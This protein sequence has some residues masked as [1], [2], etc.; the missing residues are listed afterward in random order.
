MAGV[1]WRRHAPWIALP[2]GALQSLA[3]AP[4]GLWPLG[5][6]ALVVLW[7]L[8]DGARAREA[9][10]TGFAFGAGL[11]LAGTYWLYTSIHTF[12]EAPIALALVLMLGL[13]AIMGSYTALL[14]ALVARLAPA[15]GAWRSLAALPAGWILM[16]WVRGWFLS[17]FPWLAVGYSQIDAPLVGYAP[18]LG[19]YGTG[20]ATAFTAGAVLLAASLPSRHRVLLLAAVA[21]LWTGGAVLARVEWT[22][23]S[24]PP[25]TVALVQPSISQDLKWQVSN[26]DHTLELYRQMTESALGARLVVWPES[27][28]PEAFEDA[29]PYLKSIYRDARAQR[30]D[31][32]LGLVRFDAAREQPYNGLVALG[33]DMQWYYKRR[34]VPFGEFFPVPKFVRAWMRLKNLAFVDFLAGDAHQPALDAAGQKIGATICYEDAYAVEQLAVL[35]EATLLVNVSND[36]WFGD[37]TAPH[38]HLEIARMRALEAG[39]WLMRSTNNGISALIDPHGRVVVRAPQ[40][41][42]VVLRGEVVPYTGL[43]PYAVLRNWPVLGGAVAMLAAAAFAGRRRRAPSVA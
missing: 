3:F 17:G 2:L 31:L 37:S 16:E 5:P 6:I 43:T 34:L 38:Q 14:G 26:R 15:H 20:L 7:W 9:A 30:T 11:Y 28:L 23:P 42:T 21:A 35:R 39:R 13:V 1:S 29:V 10:L 40:F 22:H 33:D 41:A 24:G 36:A 25:L 27:A 32:L 4:Y 19:I 8:W 18:V 12:G